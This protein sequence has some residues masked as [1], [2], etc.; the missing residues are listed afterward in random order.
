MENGNSLDIQVGG[1][2]YKLFKIQPVEFTVKNGLCFLQGNVI[3]YTVRHKFKNG[4]QDLEKA[5]HY[6][7]MM[8]D[9]YYP[10]KEE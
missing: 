9:F 3:K 6:L 8:M 5:A 2:H 1:N 7:Q 4:K 10:E